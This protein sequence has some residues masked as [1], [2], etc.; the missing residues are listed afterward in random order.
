MVA[1]CCRIARRNPFTGSYLP[2]VLRTL[3]LATAAAM[4]VACGGGGSGDSGTGALPPPTG[5]PSTPPPSTPPPASKGSVVVRAITSAGVP[6]RGMSVAL[7]GGFDARSVETDA[8]GEALFEDVP[9]GDAST[10]LGGAGYHSAYRRLAV[11]DGSQTR[12]TV[13][14]QRMTEAVPVLLAAYP[15][16]PSADGRSLTVEVDV[17]VLTADGSSRADLVAGD[18]G[19]EGGCGW[20]PCIVEADGRDTGLAYRAQAT[21]APFNTVAVPPGTSSA[22]GV[23]IEQSATMGTFDPQGQRLQAV[24]DYFDRVLPPIVVTLASQ[25]DTG[26]T[27][28]LTTYGGFTSDGSRFRSAIDGLRGQEAGDSRTLGAIAEMADFMKSSIAGVAGSPRQAMV[29]IGTNAAVPGDCP[30]Q[31]TCQRSLQAALDAVKAADI[32]VIAAGNIYS[33]AAEVAAGT[34]GSSVAIQDPGQ[35]PVVFRALDALAVGGLPHYRV[36]LEL[37]AGAPGVFVEGRR[38]LGALTIRIGTDTQLLLWELSIP[39]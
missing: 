3:W 10:N 1:S 24:R 16:R 33:G 19:L 20:Y 2:T 5:S 35:W 28:V 14:L 12:A 36:K 32:K 8:N 7:N 34:G 38:V 39:V 30:D 11:T 37:D 17:A 27:P 13:T 25:R 23:L 18:F 15:A 26:T 31:T 9:V 6:V 29:V 22:V 21:V 4:L